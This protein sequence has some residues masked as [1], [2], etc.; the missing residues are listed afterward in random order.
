MIRSC[1]RYKCA[2]LFSLIIM[3]SE[4]DIWRTAQA[5]V[6]RFGDDATMEAAMRADQLG[7]QGDHDGMMVW[8]R[9][10]QAYI[11]LLRTEPEGPVN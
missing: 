8:V 9:V 6:K 2:R 10:M 4:I 1:P 7:D 11:E 3:I 5:L